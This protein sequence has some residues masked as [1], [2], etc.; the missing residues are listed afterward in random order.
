MKAD[1]T[2]LCVYGL[3]FLLTMMLCVLAQRADTSKKR[4]AILYA[5]LIALPLS[6]IA[7]LRYEVG[8]DYVNYVRIFNEIEYYSLGRYITVFGME[9]LFVIMVKGMLTLGFDHSLIFGIFEIIILFFPALALI[10]NKNKLS[11]SFGMAIYYLTLYHYSLNMIRQ[12]MAVGIIMYVLPKLLQKKYVTYIA[13]VLIACLIHATS[14]IGILFVVVPLID[15]KKEI[16]RSPSLNYLTFGQTAY[17]VFILLSPV[18]LYLLYRLLFKLPILSGYAH[19]AKESADIGI[20]FI[21][22]AALLFV[23]LFLLCAKTIKQDNEIRILTGL[24]LMY[25][26]I[27]FMEYLFYYGERLS[28]YSD[29]VLVLFI[30]M[31][32][33]ANKKHRLPLMIFYALFFLYSFVSIIVLGNAGETFPYVSIFSIPA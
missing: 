29:M 4:K 26:P 10:E 1:I 2:S 18:F 28:F 30:P 24:A 25:I 13:G 6:I 21:F 14:I 32:C 12:V 19:Y 33:Y 7:G 5:F 3:G 23:P 15:G 17:S 8:T 11:I 22:F 27:S 16:R 20:G 9:P 31:I